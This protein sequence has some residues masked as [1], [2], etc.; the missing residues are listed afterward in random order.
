M[1]EGKNP[2]RAPFVPE[3]APTAHRDSF[4]RDNL[5]PAEMWPRMDFSALPELRAYKPRINAA[6]ALVDRHVAAGRGQRAAIYFEDKKWSY[7]ELADKSDRVARVL[8]EEMGLVPGNR[9]L[10]RGPNNPM[11]AAAWLGVLKAGGIAVATMP[12]LRARE[13]AY[14]IEKAEIRLALC[15]ASLGAEMEAATA[16][17]PGL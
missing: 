9:V 16:R 4:A 3:S 10:L 1:S 8:S 5:P 14:I 12:L 17:A 2:E 13:L 15:D 7:A 11:M 6:T